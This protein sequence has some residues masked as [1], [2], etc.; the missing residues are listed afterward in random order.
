MWHQI[1]SWVFP[2]NDRMFSILIRRKNRQSREK[3]IS[4]QYFQNHTEFPLTG[5]SFYHVIVESITKEINICI[6]RFPSIFADPM[7]RAFQERYSYIWTGCTRSYLRVFW[8]NDPNGFCVN[9][10]RKKLKVLKADG[11]LHWYVDTHKPFGRLRNQ[12]SLRCLW[13]KKEVVSKRIPPR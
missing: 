2:I 1:N 4:Q 13:S 10:A 3:R 5:R 7:F 11:N 9:I 12:T 8:L 6:I